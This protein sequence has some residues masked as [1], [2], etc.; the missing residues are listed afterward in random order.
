MKNT[1]NSTQTI[2]EKTKTYTSSNNYSRTKNIVNGRGYKNVDGKYISSPKK[3]KTQPADATAQCRDGTWSFS[4]N[5][6]G[7]CSGHGGVAAWL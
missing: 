6:R 2:E 4:Q 7:T 5:R 3:S 1:K